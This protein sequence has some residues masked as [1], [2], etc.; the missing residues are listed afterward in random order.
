MPVK[1]RME[2]KRPYS[3]MYYVVFLYVLTVNL[4]SFRR[5]QGLT[6][7]DLA[8][9]DGWCLPNN[10]TTTRE[11]M[12]RIGALLEQRLLNGGFLLVSKEHHSE[13][14]CLSPFDDEQVE[15]KSNVYHLKLWRTGHF[16][17]WFDQVNAERSYYYDQ[18]LLSD[19]LNYDHS[20]FETV[21][22]KLADM[23]TLESLLVRK[24]LQQILQEADGIFA[25][26]Y[27]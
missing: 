8:K 21:P 22:T 5:Q 25:K 17:S 19:M 27:S 16:A 23:Q 15:M 1:E 2:A 4:I 18:L 10:F 7:H 14:V 11:Q 26:Y 9:E 24:P 12:L 3:S 6:Y 13:V 20:I